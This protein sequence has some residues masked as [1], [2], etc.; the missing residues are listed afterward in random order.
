MGVVDGLMVVF[1]AIGISC[2]GFVVV[3]FVCCVYEEIS[4]NGVLGLVLGS[5]VGAEVGFCVFV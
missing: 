1:G 5:M 2:F 4:G 3:S